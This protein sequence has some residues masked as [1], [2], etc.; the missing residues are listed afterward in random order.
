MLNIA[1]SGYAIWQNNNLKKSIT[2][3]GYDIERIEPKL[4]EIEQK[5]SDVHGLATSIY[6]NQ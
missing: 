5:V 2:Y 1:I 4:N 3:N 6:L